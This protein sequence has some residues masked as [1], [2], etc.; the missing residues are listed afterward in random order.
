MSFYCALS[1]PGK[2]VL[3]ADNKRRVVE[4]VSEVVP[5]TGF[6]EITI[7]DARKIQRL[8]GG[9]WMVGVGISGFLQRARLMFTEILGEAKKS[10]VNPEDWIQRYGDGRSLES[11]WQ[12]FWETYEEWPPEIV[13]PLQEAEHEVLLAFVAEDAR[14]WLICWRKSD[15]FRAQ[16]F[17]GEGHILFSG[18]HLES[19]WKEPVRGYLQDV[20]DLLWAKGGQETRHRAWEILPPLF[21]WMAR[22]F[23]DRSGPTGDLICIEKA[24]HQWLLF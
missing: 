12:K 10:P 24:R 11:E 15:N 23:P 18:D 9:W 2:I 13:R 6:R 4:A 8:P 5:G 16:V 7:S 17:C 20:L 1:F 3:A 19:P 22:N 21:Q 14:P